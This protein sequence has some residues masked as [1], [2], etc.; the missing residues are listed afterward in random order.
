MDDAG[1]IVPS[2]AIGMM[3]F[4]NNAAVRIVYEVI[5]KKILVG[6]QN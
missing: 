3:I 1:D 5:A 4:Y 6:F 2:A